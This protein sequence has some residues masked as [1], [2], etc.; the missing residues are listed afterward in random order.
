MGA[1]MPSWLATARVPL[2]VSRRRLA[3]LAKLPRAAAPWALDS[4]GFTELSMFGRWTVDARTYAADVRR[5]RDEIGAL[6][7]AAPQDWM[8]EPA[9]LAKTGSTVEQHQRRTIANYLELRSLAPDLPFVPVLQGW[10]LAE[11]WRHVEMY[12]AAGVSL[13]TLPL[14]GIG[15]VCRRQATLGAGALIAS[16]AADGIRLHGFGFKTSGLRGGGACSLASADSMAWS[17][18]A[19]KSPPMVGH[20]HRSCANCLPYA[21][22]WRSD[23]LDS[24][25]EGARMRVVKEGGGQ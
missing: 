7:W 17:L 15:S 3:G 4:G 21:I 14:V 19:R 20:A 18:N 11:Y 5:F 10:G 12:D 9:I 23:L 1:H 22:Q 24:L 13:R 2:F 25:S 16:L 6:A 8:C